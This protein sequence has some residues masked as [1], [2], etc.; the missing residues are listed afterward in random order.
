MRG[1]TLLLIIAENSR[2][3]VVE[4]LINYDANINATD[5]EG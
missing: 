4:L 5:N 3:D 2:K 1:I